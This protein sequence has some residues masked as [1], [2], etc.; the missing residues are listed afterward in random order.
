MFIFY[1][2][3]YYFSN[4]HFDFEVAELFDMIVVPKA[5]SL[6]EEYEDIH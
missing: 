2:I 6:H 3:L 5:N 1:L 4:R